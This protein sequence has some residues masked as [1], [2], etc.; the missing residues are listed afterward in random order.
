ML[1]LLRY[2]P[3]AQEGCEPEKGKGEKASVRICELC[4]KQ[5]ENFKV[6]EWDASQMFLNHLYNRKM[7]TEYLV[8]VNIVPRVLCWQ[9]E[10]LEKKLESLE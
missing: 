4:K 7:L 2:L 5:R 9:S 6:E 10:A 3:C 8:N 1:N